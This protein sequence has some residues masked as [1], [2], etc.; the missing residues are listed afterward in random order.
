MTSCIRCGKTLEEFDAGGD[1]ICMNCEAAGTGHGT[2]TDVPCQRCGMYLPQTELKMWNSRLFCNYCIMDIQD[3]ERM[4][5]PER[6]TLEK[7]HDAIPEQA[8]RGAGACERCGRQ[9]D[10]LYALSGKKLCS[11]CYSEAAS[12]GTPPEGKPSM[13]GQ[14]IRVAKTALGMKQEPKLIV[15]QGPQ[16]IVFDLRRRKM[17]DKKVGVEA[18]L[19]LREEKQG[20]KP[21]QPSEKSKKSFFGLIG[22]KNEGASANPAA[23]KP[24]LIG[25]KGK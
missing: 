12:G 14:I 13:F 1:M 23:R 19:P 17:V 24:F 15:N 21:P 9:A 11:T 10:T 7:V 16:E 6:R 25:K 18:Q 5:H 4:M 3:E 8:S 22:G 2:G 20:Q